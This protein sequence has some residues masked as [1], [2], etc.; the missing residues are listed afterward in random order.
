M[1]GCI[2]YNPTG[3]LPVK[4]STVR[5][6]LSMPNATRSQVQPPSD[7]SEGIDDIV[8]SS[9]LSDVPTPIFIRRCRAPPPPYS[10][11]YLRTSNHAAEALA[12][13][14]YNLGWDT[15]SIRQLCCCTCQSTGTEFWSSFYH[16]DYSGHERPLCC[17]FFAT[18]FKPTF[19]ILS[20]IMGHSS[21][22]CV[23]WPKKD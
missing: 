9:R 20:I 8:P 19:Q 3:V 13:L 16:E 1:R 15:S 14:F 23:M 2:G 7:R 12:K 10:Y 18:S 17:L 22:V 21:R 5:R 11:Y 4:V 6:I